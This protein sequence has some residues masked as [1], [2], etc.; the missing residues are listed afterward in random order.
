[1]F[2]TAQVSLYPLGQTEFLPP[3]DAV[4]A[5]L[6]DSGLEVRVGPMSTLVA[7]EEDVVFAAL[8]QAFDVASRSGGFVLVTALTNG[9]TGPDFKIK[10]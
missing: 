4:I 5:T 7:G 8:R 9:Y 2:V 6:Q 1:M 3:I 10:P